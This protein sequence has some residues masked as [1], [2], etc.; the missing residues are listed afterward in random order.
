MKNKANIHK[1]YRTRWI[2]LSITVVLA[3]V[4]LFGISRIAAQIKSSEMQK[5]RLWAGAITQRAE[6]VTQTEQFFDEIAND[7]RSKMEFYTRAQ[8]IAVTQVLGNQENLFFTDYITANHSIPVIIIDADSNI[9]AYN[10]IDLP[11]NCQ[12]LEG[13]LMEEFSQN[14]PIHYSVWGMHF[15]L[16][17]KDSKIYTD[18]RR[19][20][21]NLTRSF[22]DEVTNNSVNVPVLVVDSLQEFVIG[23]G[24]IPERMFNTPEKL[25][26]K[27]CEMAE[28]NDPIVVRLPNRHKAYVF[29]ETTPMLKALR[30]IP[31]CYLFILFAIILISFN[32]FTTARTMEQNR[33]WVGM[34]KETAHQLGTPISSLLAWHEYLQG[35][36]YTE[37]YAT[38][39]K[40]DLDRLET[41]AH[42]FGK[43]GSVPELK[44]EDV[45]AVIQ[46]TLDYLHH[47][48]SRNIHFVTNFPNEPVVVPLNRY[49]FEWVI[50][51]I[52]KNAIDAMNGSGTFTVIVSSDSR[53]VYIDLSDTGKGMTSSQQ[54]H[55][56]DS[57]YTTKTRGWGL[58][59][60][61]ARRIINEYHRGRIYLKYSVEGQGSVF[62]IELRRNQP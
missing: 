36:E 6:L 2:L 62:R 61:L 33:V 29:Y 28:A 21:H 60:S 9:T 45:C 5:V 4:A 55:I 7:E 53:Y 23:S 54:K 52:C 51:N 44:P 15:T 57:G 13:S 19:T 34:A 16:Y 22:L 35:K 12:R 17:Y 32:L 1:N 14:K 38:E 8:Q 41:V 18:M 42:R 11:A 10:N 31:L 40:K 47:R 59:L 3:F 25:S 43:I 49:L 27:I 48:T 37:A 30:W 26:D 24:N 56:F 46:S 20:L 50:E 58:G 39:V